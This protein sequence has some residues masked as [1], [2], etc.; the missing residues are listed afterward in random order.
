MRYEKSVYNAW[1][2]SAGIPYDS[3]I[4]LLHDFNGSEQV[5]EMLAENHRDLSDYI[6]VECIKKLRQE[7]VSEKMN[8]L[9]SVIK[10]HRIHSMT[11]LEDIYPQSLRHI[12]DPPGILFYQGNAECMQKEKITAMIGSRA[13]SYAG[14]QAA[15]KIARELSKSGVTVASGLAY[16]ID[17]ACHQGCI[18]GGSPTIAVMGCGLDIIYPYRNRDLKE[19]I[20]LHDGLIL[21]EYTPGTKPMPYHFPYRNRIIS[22]LSKIVILVE[23]KIRSGS[24]TTVDHALRQGKDVYVYPGDPVS[25]MYEGN[26]L[27]LRD[28]ARYFSTAKDI[29]ADMNWL[30]NL[31]HVGQ[32]IDCSTD[33]IPRNVSEKAVYDTL[34]RGTLGFDELM[35]KTG[36]TSSEL[37]RTLTVLQIHKVIDLLP[38]KKYQI[39]PD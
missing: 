33:F 1:L 7:A 31:L 28:G 21:S 14:L 23:A 34:S 27:L 12:P 25:P 3:L 30:D 19:K 29:L 17:S 22:G 15:E 13:A 16:G 9:S 32:N 4:P 8:T 26:R 5:F 2:A 35:Q 20:I 18:Q 6:P 38:G 10:Q 11:I 24:M 39:R 36:L 37:M